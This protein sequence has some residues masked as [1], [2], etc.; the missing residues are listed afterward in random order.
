MR[1]F[2][3]TLA[4]AAALGLAAPAYAHEA[5][6]WLVRF[7]GS[8]IDPKSDNGS[9]DL[10]AAGL[11][12]VAVQD[13]NVDSQIGVTFN[14]T[15]MYT[16]N[17]GIELLA[18]LP[19]EHDIE[20]AGLPGTAATVTHLPPTLSLQYHFMPDAV[21]QPYVGAGLNLTWFLDDSKEEGLV[22]ADGLLGATTG[23]DVDSTSVGLAAQ[24]GFDYIVNDTWFINFDVRWIDISTDA[25]LTVDGA[26]F[27]TAKV[28]I[29]P[30]VY[31]LHIGYRF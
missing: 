26:D 29:D 6:D 30:I 2:A 17:L 22:A 1:T 23:L 19:Y 20:V 10:T 14:I 16:A 4:L 18:A 15:Y 31:G 21:F 8:N 3:S 25:T 13:V 5:G 11:E 12:G 7:G 28:D 24:V 27:S 9:L